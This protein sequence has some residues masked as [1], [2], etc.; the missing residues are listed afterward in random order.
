M[1]Q[2]LLRLEGHHI[3]KE[4]Y[5]C[6]NTH[7]ILVPGLS[8]KYVARSQSRFLY[9]GMVKMC[10]L[11]GLLTLVALRKMPTVDWVRDKIVIILNRTT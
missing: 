10:M 6:N 7:Q 2:Q 11:F 8:S 1:L 4:Y 3:I 9:F 5:I